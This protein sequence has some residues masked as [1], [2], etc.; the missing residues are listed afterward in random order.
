MVTSYKSYLSSGCRSSGGGGDAAAPV[1]QQGR[2][3]Q[4]FLC[5]NFEWSG[6]G[7]FPSVLGHSAADLITNAITTDV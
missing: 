3:K 4:F 2:I 7:F 5:F 6:V 1:V